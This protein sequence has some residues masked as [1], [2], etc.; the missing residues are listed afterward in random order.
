MSSLNSLETMALSV[1]CVEICTL[2]VILNSL[3]S[4]HVDGPPILYEV[5]IVDGACAYHVAIAAFVPHT[6][7]IMGFFCKNC[8]AS[9]SSIIAFTASI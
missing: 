3:V 5:C 2:Y 6:V 1:I 7:F 9:H 4:R 8:Y